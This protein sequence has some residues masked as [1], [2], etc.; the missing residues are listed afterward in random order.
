MCQ[1]PGQAQGQ[2][3]QLVLWEYLQKGLCCNLVNFILNFP[4]EL[5]SVCVCMWG[6]CP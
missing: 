3:Y 5:S 6:A 2:Q 4:E 1:T